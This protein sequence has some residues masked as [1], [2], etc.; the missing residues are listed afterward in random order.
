MSMTVS[1]GTAYM[2]NNLSSGT[3]SVSA[4]LFLL[5]GPLSRYR[6]QD[7]S[8]LLQIVGSLGLWAHGLGS[9]VGVLGALLET[10]ACLGPEDHIYARI[11]QRM[12]SGIPLILALVT[13][14]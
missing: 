14:M 2:V 12:I 13:R 6:K 8:S 7:P 3:L 5:R 4:R 10:T 9:P 1:T 11:L